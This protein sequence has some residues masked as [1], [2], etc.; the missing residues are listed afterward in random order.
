M[1]VK[2]FGNKD[3]DVRIDNIWYRTKTK[4]YY[5]DCNSCECKGCNPSD[6]QNKPCHIFVGKIFERIPNRV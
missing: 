4:R 5:H 1:D 6:G 3:I 2:V